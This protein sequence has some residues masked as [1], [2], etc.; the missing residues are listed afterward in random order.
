M[1]SLPA[2]TE[3]SAH[4][5]ERILITGAT[6]F[7]GQ[8]I[9]GTLLETH[10]DARLVVLLREKK[11]Q[12]VLERLHSI[13]DKA[14][15]PENRQ[16]ALA[17]FEIFP[18]DD[19]SSDKCGLSPADYQAVVAGL[20]RIIHS[21]ATVRFDHTLEYARKINVKGTQNVL[22]IAEEAVKNGSLKS[23]TYI[24]TAFVAGERNGL[25]RED[26]LDIGQSFRNTYERT[27]CEAE[28]LVRSRM[29]V[30][31]TVI[32]RPSIIVGD[33]RTGETTS[34]KT[35]YWPLKIYVKHHWRS[36]PGFPDAVIDLVPV[37]FVAKAV[38][39]LG[40]D[41]KALGGCFHLCAGSERGSTIGEVATLASSFFNLLPPRYIN[42]KLF[43][44]L[45]RPFLYVLLW[46]KKRRILRDAAVFR[47]YFRVKSQFDTTQSE[48]LLNAH[49]IKTPDVSQYLEK[50]FR[51]CQE[52][53][54]GKHPRKGRS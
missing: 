23:F 49:G 26:E 54:W 34:F 46:G 41:N 28:K 3:A 31:P 6:G 16:E 53:D 12:S 40:F 52:T 39:A 50:L 38:V 11:G 18:A 7:L 21:A 32:A 25:V 29:K 4:C 9:I 33:S 17:R 20:T 36:V 2:S 10:P 43:F 22:D 15:P 47:P 8:K 19:I 13:V 37:D 14:C 5:R 24:G 1:T 27:K 35:M 30:I 44:F 42:L 48:K 45:I 51:F